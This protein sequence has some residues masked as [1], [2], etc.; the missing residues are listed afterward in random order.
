[1]KPLDAGVDVLGVLTE[2]HHVR[3]LGT[4]HG[5][6]HALEPTH[7]TQADIEIKLLAHGHIDGTNATTNGRGERPFD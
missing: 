6:G 7:G 3:E 1:M 4:L 2:D 5:G